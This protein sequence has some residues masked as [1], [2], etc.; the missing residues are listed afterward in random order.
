MIVVVPATNCAVCNVVSQPP[1][2]LLGSERQ[3]GPGAGV[4]P[5]VEGDQPPLVEAGTR[6]RLTEI[7]RT[8]RVAG[9][10]SGTGTDGP[11]QVAPEATRVCIAAP[12]DKTAVR[13][14]AITDLHRFS[15]WAD[16]GS[17]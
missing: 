4:M 2:I 1:N 14:R 15:R 17:S 16:T 7:Q 13:E 12:H 10:V 5:D 11:V 9:L 3:A 8:L 6:F